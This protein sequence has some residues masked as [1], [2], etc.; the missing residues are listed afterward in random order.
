MHQ[1]RDHSPAARE[2]AK[3]DREDKRSIMPSIFESHARNLRSAIDRARAAYIKKSRPPRLLTSHALFA[4]AFYNSTHED[5]I[6]FTSSPWDLLPIELHIDIFSQCGLRDIYN[7]RL[8]S[9]AF[10]SIVSQH[11]PAIVRGY[12]RHRRRGTLPQP[13]IPVDMVHTREPEDDVVLLSDLFPP[14][15][16]RFGVSIFSFVY[17]QGLQRR[18]DTCGRLAGYLSE[19]VVDRYFQDEPAARRSF[20][21]N[22][23]DLREST[24]RA[25][26]LLQF[27]LTPLMFY[28]SFFLETYAKL[29]LDHQNELL[30]VYDAG[31]LPVPMQPQDRAA[32]YLRLQ[33]EILQ[34]PPFTITKN[35]ISTHHVLHLL[36]SYLRR[37][38]SPEPPHDQNDDWISM[39]LYESGLAR[40]V[41]FFAAEKGGG[42]VISGGVSQRA[43]RKEFMRN[44][45]EDWDRAKSNP[46]VDVV[47]G[48]GEEGTKPPKVGQIWFKAAKGEMGKRGLVPHF[49]EDWVEVWGGRISVGCENCVGEEGWLA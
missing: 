35:L 44:M 19:R 18:Q 9:R 46:G 42:G 26:R 34:T 20:G 41:E 10:R 15:R 36:V 28:A 23:K 27:K 31:R 48:G 8:V 7:L 43:K 37:T 13:E 2:R 14:P 39:L 33:I 6:Y 5:L 25:V 16:N 12:L 30:I 1:L 32:E 40:I 4:H 38:I 22:R 3:R 24:E 45:Q 29:R 21:N 11:E 49:S 47:Y 17:L